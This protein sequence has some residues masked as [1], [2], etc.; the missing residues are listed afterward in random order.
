[1]K[2]METMQKRWKVLSADESEVRELQEALNIHPILCKLL[3]NRGIRSY[4]EAKAYFRPSLDHLHDPFLMKDM[5]KAVIR[6]RKAIDNREKILFFGD[7]DVDGTTAVS[8]MYNFF[9]KIHDPID[10]Y[11][12]DRYKEGYGISIEGIDYA[13]QKDCSLIIALDCGIKAIEQVDYANSLGIDFI[14][15]D[16]HR[17]GSEL[18]KAHAIL[19]PQRTDCSYPYPE[20]SGCGIGFK[21]AEAY[22][23]HQ[24]LPF[25][26]VEDLLDLV[27]IS[28]ASDIVP[29]TGENRVMAFYGLQKINTDPRPGIQAL[30]DVADLKKRLTI[31]DVVFVLGPRINAAGRMTHGKNAVSLLISPDQATAANH[32]TLLHHNNDERKQMD[33]SITEEALDMLNRDPELEQ[34]KS[35]V[36]YQS[37]WHKGV[38]GIVA[39]RLIEQY[40]RPTIVFT[41]SNGKLAGSA[42]SVPGFDIYEALSACREHIDQFGG[43]TYAAGLTLL[44][45][46]LEAF[47]A[48]FETV[49]ASRIEDSALVPEIRIDAELALKDIGKKFYNII[50]QMAPFGPG[51]MKPVFVTRSVK[52]SGYSKIV[53][54][55]HLKLAVRQNGSY[56]INGIGFGMGHLYEPLVR[57]NYFDLCYTLDENE[58]NDQVTIQM[59]VKDIQ[60]N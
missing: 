53:K 3:V 21:L 10:F 1:M 45:G 12:P 23:Q 39:S 47:S 54:E 59:K 14:I 28:I 34:R 43:H 27:V 31:G 51:N 7:Y 8:L 42:R 32:A 16:H 38:I 55:D 57:K 35:T 15:C 33:S 9:R 60:P 52:D 49:V 56:I 46:Q 58:W 4:D 26:Q 48:Q 17:P 36:V 19:D 44:P 29:I 40:H 30:I 2:M 37:H 11:I 50:K 5:E 22:A 41:E 20:L 6:I 24:N 13:K 25:E 18:P